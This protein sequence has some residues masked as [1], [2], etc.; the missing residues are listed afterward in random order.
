MPTLA[1]NAKKNRSSL[2]ISTM[3]L[4]SARA[5]QAGDCVPTRIVG[6]WDVVGVHVDSRDA[7]HARYYE[8]DPLLV[9]RSLSIAAGRVLF[10]DSIDCAHTQWPRWSTQ[11]GTLFRQAFSRAPSSYASAHP[12]LEDFGLKAKTAQPVTVYPLCVE[13]KQKPAEW[14]KGVWVIPYQQ[15]EL[16][17]RDDPQY[18]LRLA[19]RPADAKPAAVSFDCAKA[20]TP[21]EKTICGDYDL[22]S[23]D[24]SVVRALQDFLKARPEKEAD[25][26]QGQAEYVRQRDACGTDVPCIGLAE[27]SRVLELIQRKNLP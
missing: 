24:R 13:P 15:D 27:Y 26:R 8:D 20:G 16:L 25:A 17:F 7:L 3:L 19:R 11:W 23:W 21:A 22:A 4:A 10:S 5:T 18:V 12:T 14:S 9:G 1:A 2:A 6:T